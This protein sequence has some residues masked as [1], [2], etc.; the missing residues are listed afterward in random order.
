[1]SG[2]ILVLGKKIFEIP[3]LFQTRPRDLGKSSRMIIIFFRPGGSARAP[4][5]LLTRPISSSLL[6]FQ[7]GAF[8]NRTFA[9]P[10]K[11]QHNRWLQRVMSRHSTPPVDKLSEIDQTRVI[12]DQ[13]WT[14]S[15]VRLP[16]RSNGE[17]AF[18][19]LEGKSGGKSMV[20]FVDFVAVNWF[21]VACPTGT[22]DG[23]V[24]MEYHESEGVTDP[25]S[26]LLFKCQKKMMDVRDSDRLLYSTWLITETTAKNLTQTIKEHQKNPPKY[27]V[28]GDKSVVARGSAISSSNPTGHNCFTFAKMILRNLDDARIQ[29]PEGGL[30]TWIGSA[31][32]RY[33]VDKQV[34][35]S[36]K[37]CP[38]RTS[39]SQLMFAFLA[40]GV[41]VA[42]LFKIFY[43]SE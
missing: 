34:S 23:I 42:F 32:S 16:D 2:N 40:G 28:L 14:V 38:Y 29:L 20:W 11:R 27:H 41:F 12:T 1:M 36:T 26:R 35:K 6:E 24:R 5:L 13:H 43:L 22:H 17:H 3:P 31:T 39:W 8:A 30:D 18:I 37:R 9:H 10:K 4:P 15:L 21:D 25:E 33:L 19:V 7:H